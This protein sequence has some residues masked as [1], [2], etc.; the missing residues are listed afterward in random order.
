MRK[1]WNKFQRNMKQN[2]LVLVREDNIG[3]SHWP[4]ARV[5]ETYPEKDGI[6]RSAKINLP[7]SVLTRPCNKLCMLEECN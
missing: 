6:V 7:N 4:L 3:Q 1:K 2:D 5:I